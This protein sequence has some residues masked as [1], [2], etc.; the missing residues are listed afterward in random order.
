MAG[1]QRIPTVSRPG[2]RVPAVKPAGELRGSAAK[3]GYDRTWQRLRLA[4]LGRQPL[5]VRCAKPAKHVDHIQP[6]AKGGPRLDPA[7]LQSLCHSC[8]SRKTATEDRR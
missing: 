4:H 2:L 1:P 5:C 8:H 6:I 3:R 7:N